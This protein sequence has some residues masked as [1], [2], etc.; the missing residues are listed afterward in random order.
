MRTLLTQR[1]ADLE[2]ARTLPRRLRA[3]GLTDVGA[4]AYFPVASSDAGALDI[5]N[6]T[7]VRA[8]LISKR[9]ASADD[10][11]AHLAAI[12]TGHLD[13]ATSPLLSAWARRPT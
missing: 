12:R 5:A 10:I 9:L 13:V 2:F 11:A 1:G 3:Q 7:Q 8:A 6:L 4:D